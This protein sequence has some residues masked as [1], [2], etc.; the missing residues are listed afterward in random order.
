M[1]GS[2]DLAMSKT[3][4]PLSQHLQSG[5]GQGSIGKEAH[6]KLYTIDPM[7]EVRFTQQ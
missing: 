1:L 5:G 6:K 2:K 3:Q 7:E 4:R